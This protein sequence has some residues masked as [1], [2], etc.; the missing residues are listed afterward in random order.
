[1]FQLS[2]HQLFKTHFPS[3]L[4][5][6]EGKIFQ[7]GKGELWKEN[8]KLLYPSKRKLSEQPYIYIHTYIYIYIWDYFHLL[9]YPPDKAK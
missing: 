1:M 9:T 3:R 7:R 5:R 8:P 4:V 6:L 2:Y